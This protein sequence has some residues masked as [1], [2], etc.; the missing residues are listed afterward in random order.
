MYICLG[1]AGSMFKHNQGNV[2]LQRQAYGSSSVTDF[3]FQLYFLKLYIYIYI[4]LKYKR[5]K[6]CQ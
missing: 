5:L 2:K 1:N 4:I 3:V 6:Y